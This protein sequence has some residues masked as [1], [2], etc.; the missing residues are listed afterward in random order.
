MKKIT[1]LAFALL[2]IAC[3]PATQLQVIK[4]AAI[5]LPDHINVLATIDRSKPSSGFVDVLEGGVTGESIHQDRD[6]R[7]RALEVLSTTLT[8][9]P[10]FE[11]IHTGLE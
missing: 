5:N 10:R 8:R 9:T 7:R 4:P 2:I 6:G 3:K 11:V 1:F